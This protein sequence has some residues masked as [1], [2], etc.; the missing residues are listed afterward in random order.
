MLKVAALNAESSNAIE[1][2]D[3][4]KYYGRPRAGVLAVDHKRYWVTWWDALPRGSWRG[5]FGERPCGRSSQARCRC[6]GA[7]SPVWS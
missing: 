5:S 4:T 6:R 3:L 1:V 2:S 7:G